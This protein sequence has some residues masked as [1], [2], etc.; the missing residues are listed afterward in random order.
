MFRLNYLLLLLYAA[1]LPI[2][3][4]AEIDLPPAPGSHVQIISTELDDTSRTDPFSPNHDNRRLMVTS[5]FPLDCKRTTYIPYMPDGVAA[6]NDQQFSIFGVEDGTFESF[7]IESCDNPP[8]KNRIP[9][10]TTRD[11]DQYPLVI[12]SP[13]VSSSRLMYSELLAALASQGIAVVAID[14]PYDANAIQYPSG[15][16]VHGKNMTSSMPTIMLNLK[17]RVEDISFVLDHVKSRSAS[18]QNQIFPRGSLNKVNVDKPVVIGHSFGGASAAQAMA[19]DSRFSG[20]ANIDGMMFGS[21]VGA[22][23]GKPFMQ[24]KS[25][26]AS[27]ER[28]SSWEQ[29]MKNLSGWKLELLVEGM[30]HEG[31]TDLPLLFDSLPNGDELRNSAKK[32]IGTLPGRRVREIVAAYVGAAVEYFVDGQEDELLNGPSDEFPEVKYLNS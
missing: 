18:G 13:G 14:H 7:N 28:D 8:R 1:I 22:G 12:F 27:E 3:T 20:G 15:E 5:F 17:T 29:F 24:M 6:A 11:N 23:F 26:T 21:V 9:E 31:F 16:V 25:E 10:S 30:R 32:L 19:V 4:L 2:A